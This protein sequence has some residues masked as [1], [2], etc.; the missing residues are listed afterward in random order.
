MTNGFSIIMALQRNSFTRFLYFSVFSVKFMFL[1]FPSFL[2]FCFYFTLLII[3][4]YPFSILSSYFASLTHTVIYYEVRLDVF[5]L[6]PK[7]R[8]IKLTFTTSFSVHSFL[9]FQ[10]H[11]ITEIFLWVSFFFR[12][13]VNSEHFPKDFNWMLQLH[14]VW[15][16]CFISS[17]FYHFLCFIWSLLWNNS[18]MSI[19]THP[20]ENNQCSSFFF[21]SVSCFQWGNFYRMYDFIWFSVAFKVEHNVNG[22]CQALEG[23]RYVIFVLYEGLTHVK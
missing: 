9:P 3:F 14:K 15:A 17:I 10:Q 16:G 7:S 4:V 13:T 23:E 6:H 1:L 19:K 11:S 5:F 12:R 2:F 22:K 20:L 18:I 8:W 21:S